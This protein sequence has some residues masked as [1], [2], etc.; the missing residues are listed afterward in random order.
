MITTLRSRLNKEEDGFTLIELMVVVLIIGIL[1][2]IAIPTFLGAQDKAKDRAAQSDLRNA[3]TAAKSMAT[4][5]AGK[6]YS[7]GTTVIDDA[8]MEAAEPSLDFDGTAADTDTVFVKTAAAGADIV[9]VRQTAGSSNTFYG[10]TATSSGVV[11][12]C[13]AALLADIDTGAECVT[14]SATATW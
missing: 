2:A 11:K 6:F 5:S 4:D 14:V 10:I 8:A 3:L 12:R 13:K 9:F 7:A 1:V